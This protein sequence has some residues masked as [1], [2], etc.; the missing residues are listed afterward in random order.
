MTSPAILVNIHCRKQHAD[1]CL[2]ARFPVP[3]IYIYHFYFCNLMLEASGE[4]H[5]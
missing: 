4:N 3:A 2:D 1:T 5:R